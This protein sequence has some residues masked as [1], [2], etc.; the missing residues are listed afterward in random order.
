M[1]KENKLRTFSKIAGGNQT[2]VGIKK[3]ETVADDK[4]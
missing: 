2:F 1:R 3:K 4:T